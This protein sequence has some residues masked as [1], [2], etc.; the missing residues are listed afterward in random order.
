MKR[1]YHVRRI[2]SNRSYTVGQLADLFEVGQATIREWIKQGLP[3][4]DDHHR[5]MMH[6]PAIRDW[7]RER[8]AA[9]RWKCG[10]NELPCFG[11]KGPRKIEP[12]SFKIVT[13]NTLK[14]RIEGTCISCG[15]TIGRGDVKTNQAALEQQ[16]KSIKP[17][18]NDAPIASIP[19]PQ[20]PL[21]HDIEKEKRS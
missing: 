9:R 18:N 6:G 19:Y 17:T 10:P 11:C 8:Q 12:G 15:Q 13:G 2:K 21:N 7:L 5:K 16:F 1:T 4:I 14:I 20:T 3:T